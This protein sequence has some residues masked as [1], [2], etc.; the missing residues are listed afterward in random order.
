MILAHPDTAQLAEQAVRLDF[1]QRLG[2]AP[3]KQL[4]V[5]RSAC[6]AG[7]MRDAATAELERRRRLS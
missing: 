4:R 6:A 1:V 5:M 2:Q 7:W 3:E